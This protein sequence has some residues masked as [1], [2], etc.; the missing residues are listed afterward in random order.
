MVYWLLVLGVALLAFLAGAGGGKMA[1]E[2]V[3]RVPED[4]SSIQQALEAAA[5]GG[6]IRVAA[7][8]YSEN[9][10]ITKSVRL[11]GAGA[12][13]T[14]LKG[15]QPGPVVL[16]R[17]LDSEKG[18]L[19]GKKLVP[20]VSILG[21]TLEHEQLLNADQFLKMAEKEVPTAVFIEGPAQVALHKNAIST[22]VTLEGFIV[23]MKEL[24][25]AAI[26]IG[27]SAQLLAQENQISGS[28]F[29]VD[30]AHATFWGNTITA[31]IV[32]NTA[33]ALVANNTMQ[34]P[35]EGE[36]SMTAGITV[37]LGGQATIRDNQILGYETGILL[38]AGAN[39][40]LEGNLLSSG[41][42][43][44]LMKFDATASLF[45]NQITTNKGY[46]VVLWQ[47]PCFESRLFVSEQL[48][49]RGRVYG[50]GNEI[51]DNQKSDLCPPAFPWPPNFKKP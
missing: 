3:W 20:V 1:T 16:I 50:N 22:R 5:E 48:A 9:L 45:K 8:T 47:L 27:K 25:L 36:R 44:V 6:T 21:F 46:G 49:F 14:Q 19:K 7:G 2:R 12:E 32:I 31:S 17:S 38:D 18:Q 42:E 28:I 23:E 34:A 24:P 43:G 15:R 11:L 29:V 10:L 37:S 13:H 41:Q 26:L 4:F 39:A 40:Y 35:Q 33:S 51:R 30:Q